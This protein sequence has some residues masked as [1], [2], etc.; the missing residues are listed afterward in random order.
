MTLV[1]VH[2]LISMDYLM[3][4]MMVMMVSFH[5]LAICSMILMILVDSNV[6]VSSSICIVTFNTTIIVL[7]W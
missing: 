3:M 1:M 7:V 6:R 5:L 4:T 2:S